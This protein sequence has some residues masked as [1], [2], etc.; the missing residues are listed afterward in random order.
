MAK[1]CAK[2]KAGVVIMHMQ[3]VPGT[4]QKKPAYRSVMGE[5]IAYLDKAMLVALNA[6][7]KKE[8]IIIDPG[9]GFGKTLEHNLEILKNLRELKV[10]GAPILVGTSRKAFIGKILN[11]APSER[12]MGTVASCVIAGVNGANIVRVHD[13]G[14]VAQALKLS[15]AILN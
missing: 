4:M 12:I 7:V 6:G 1:I 13:V 9:I 3:G 10:L 14:P 15:A 11:A 8:R 5:I 2:Y